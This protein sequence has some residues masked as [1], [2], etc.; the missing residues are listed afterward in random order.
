MHKHYFGRPHIDLF[1]S[2]LK[3][4]LTIYCSYRPDPNAKLVDAFTANWGTNFNYIFLPF[5]ILLE[6]MVEDKTDTIVIAPL[7][8][9]Q[10]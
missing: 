6:K 8:T 10:S 9:T 1:A 7:W 5:P 4:K 2:R 3:F